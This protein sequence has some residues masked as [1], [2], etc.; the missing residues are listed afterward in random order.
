MTT[1][2]RPSG[3]TYEVRRNLGV[4][5]KPSFDDKRDTGFV[6]R[7]GMTF[8]V[9]AEPYRYIAL[10]DAMRAHHP[11]LI[12]ILGREDEVR[13]ASEG[14]ETPSPCDVILAA[15]SPGHVLI[16]GKIGCEA[17][18]LARIIH[19]ISK[20]RRQLLIEINQVPDDRK[21]QVALV[22]DKAQKGTLVLHLEDQRKRLDP[23]FVSSM[24]SPDYKIRVIVTARTSNQARRALGHQYWR[25]LMHIALCPMAQRRAAIPR[26]L[27][28]HLAARGSILRVAE[29]TPQNQRALL[30]NPWRENLRALR[31][32]AVRLDAIARAGFSRSQAADALGIARQTFYNWYGITMRLTKPLV[33]EGRASALIAA[34]TGRPPAP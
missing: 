5:L 26:L 30:I 20:R 3:S 33:P 15:D 7:P 6:L 1:T 8:L 24:F 4:A 25:P 34:Q 11:T 21:S 31:Q 18:E 17:E 19:E 22:K 32:A 13:T 16:T 14:G 12:E 10:D 27:D 2:D 23:V 9:G 29:L 28:E